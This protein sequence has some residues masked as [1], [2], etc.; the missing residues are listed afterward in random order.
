MHD[1][2][3]VHVADGAGQFVED[4]SGFG[5]RYVFAFYDVVKEFL[6]RTEFCCDVDVFFVFVVLV[7]FHDVGVVLS[8]AIRTSSRRMVN[9]LSISFSRRAFWRRSICLSARELPV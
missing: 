5:F 9:S 7:H 6:A 8:I 4:C 3:V 1:V 2:V